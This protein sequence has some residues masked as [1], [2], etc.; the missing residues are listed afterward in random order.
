M[1]GK[2]TYQCYFHHNA[3]TRLELETQTLLLRLQ[4]RWPCT[5]SRAAFIRMRA[6]VAEFAAVDPW[7][8]AMARIVRFLAEEQSEYCQARAPHAKLRCLSAAI[9]MLVHLTPGRTSSGAPVAI[10]RRRTRTPYGSYPTPPLVARAIA[11]HLKDSFIRKRRP[12]TIFDPSIEGA[13]ILLECSHVFARRQVQLIGVDRSPAAIAACHA[14]F[15]YAHRQNPDAYLLPNLVRGDAFQVM[16]T[17]D[18]IDAFVNNPPWGERRF[19]DW[20]DTHAGESYSGAKEPYILFVSRGLQILK[21]GA[22]F[23]LVLPGQLASAKNA[24]KLRA[25]LAEDC[26]FTSITTLPRQCFPRATVRALLLLG[27]KRRKGETTQRVYLVHYPMTPRLND[28]CKPTTRTISQSRLSRSGRPWFPCISVE[29]KPNFRAKTIN[30]GDIADISIGIIPYRVGRGTPRQTEAIVREKSYTLAAFE[31]GSV[32]ILRSRHVLS[33]RG[34]PPDEYMRLG[35]HLAYIGD[36]GFSRFQRRVL[37]RELCARDG[38]LVAAPAPAGVVPR[39]GVFS[40]RLAGISENVLCAILNSSTIAQYVRTTCDGVFRESFNRIRANDLRFMPM[41]ELLASQTLT[42][43]SPAHELD[44]TVR[45][46]RR[47]RRLERRVALSAK[48]DTLVAEAYKQ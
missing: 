23:G 17:L 18:P 26:V 7:A 36:H 22:P 10:N 48:I 47:S 14:L 44:Q 4:D 2:S 43:G 32:P 40:I 30:L 12:I 24:T 16:E 15:A 33:Y 11:L 20:L 3:P 35:P 38:R 34:D 39:Y 37:V 8:S 21:N 42:K 5:C 29:R 28:D 31:P 41:P 46:L 6:T 13:P 45:R 27:F 19:H 1:E 9:A 25:R